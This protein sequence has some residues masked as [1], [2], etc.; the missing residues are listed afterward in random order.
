[1]AMRPEAEQ[2]S[3]HVHSGAIRQGEKEGLD[4][5]QDEERLEAHLCVREVTVTTGLLE[6]WNIEMMEEWERDL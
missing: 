3:R 1:M 6:E 5:H 4:R 2:Q